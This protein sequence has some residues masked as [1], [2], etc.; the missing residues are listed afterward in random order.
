MATI[1][2]TDGSQ[3]NVDVA[4]GLTLEQMQA[5]VG[6][7]VEFVYLGAPTRQGRT[8][9]VRVLVVDEE[10]R[11]KAKPVNHAATQ[12]LRAARGAL[13]VD[14]VGDV[15]VATVLNP[16]RPDERFV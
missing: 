9:L 12:Q 2:R 16:G 10:G 15:L 5:A 4:S 11:L 1:L 14:L 3:E 13:A 6:G 7:Y 8:V